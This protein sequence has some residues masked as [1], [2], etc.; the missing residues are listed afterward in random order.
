MGT[1]THRLLVLCC[2]CACRPRSVPP[3]DVRGPTPSDLEDAIARAANAVLAGA[4]AAQLDVPFTAVAVGRPAAASEWSIVV[5][6]TVASPFSIGDPCAL[7]D[8]PEV[9]VCRADGNA[10]LCSYEGVAA[11]LRLHA[12]AQCDP[13]LASMTP[14]DVSTLEGVPTA[15]TV[16]LAHELGHI[17]LDHDGGDLEPTAIVSGDARAR[18]QALEAAAAA[19]GPARRREAAADEVAGKIVGALIERARERDSAHADFVELGLRNQIRAAMICL[20]EVATCFE[21]E[22]FQ[23]P[24]IATA[25]PDPEAVRAHAERLMC[26]ALRAPDGSL[27]PSLRGTHG[28]WALRMGRFEAGRPPV[29][30]PMPE[31]GALSADVAD[32]DAVFTF[33]AKHGADYA[34]ALATSMRARA[35][36]FDPSTCDDQSRLGSDVCAA[37]EVRLGKPVD[38]RV[39]WSRSKAPG[40]AAPVR[41]DGHV[42]AVDASPIAV[43][44][45]LTAPDRIALVRG[46]EVAVA[47]APCRIAWAQPQDDASTLVA[48]ESPGGMA[49]V[50]ASTFSLSL[51]EDA[52][53]PGD[54]ATAVSAAWAGKVDGNTYVSG[55]L[56]AAGGFVARLDTDGLHEIGLANPQHCHMWTRYGAHQLFPT[57]GAGA[58]ALPIGDP[59]RVF[60]LSEDLTRIDWEAG[61]M[62]WR[63]WADERGVELGVPHVCR[64]AADG[65][66]RCL[67]DRLLWFDPRRKPDTALDGKLT[68]DPAALQG[69]TTF[70]FCDLPNKTWV[71]LGGPDRSRALEIERGSVRREVDLG[72][73]SGQQ[74]WCSPQ[75]AVVVLEHAVSSAVHV[76]E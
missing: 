52:A 40:T 36:T 69:I 25:E 55:R 35:S 47:K 3:Q 39:S 64:P 56:G 61:V 7:V 1:Q 15:L 48:C 19:N 34:D 6:R 23:L 8:R 75:R 38:H 10:V 63:L 72:A 44:I 59:T 16:V 21:I 32:I 53:R 42:V 73:S 9:S 65:R 37:I 13:S 60:G 26:A 54:E 2:A 50:T 27:M 57:A 46:S 30:D 41:L 31:L 74:L 66:L 4:R 51:F 49:V 76:L 43:A 12:N 24:S 5:D 17:M 70:D 29:R 58:F 18:L 68:A 20:D 45:G 11:L 71:L 62:D 22:G 14:V 28:D 67:T 33:W